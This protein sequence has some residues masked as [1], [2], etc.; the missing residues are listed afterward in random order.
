MEVFIVSTP[1]YS[2]NYKA[3]LEGFPVQLQR[4]ARARSPSG[5]TGSHGQL[6]NQAS[7]L[8]N[9]GQLLVAGPQGQA[10][11]SSGGADDCI[12][13]GYCSFC[14][15]GGCLDRYL[16]IDWVKLSETIRQ[17]AAKCLELTG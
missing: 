15:D 16:S 4:H 3:S 1:T 2:G 17:G 13:C 9:L 11:E 5:P 12:G 6:A 7:A 14:P 8:M 10:K